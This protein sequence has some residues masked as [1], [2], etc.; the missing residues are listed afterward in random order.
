MQLG[1]TPSARFWKITF[2]QIEKQVLEAG[3]LTLAEVQDYR[4]LMES[5]EYRWLAPM[6]MSVWGRR[7][8]S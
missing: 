8:T 4:T 2:D 1:G 3:H 6:F 5:P 7:I